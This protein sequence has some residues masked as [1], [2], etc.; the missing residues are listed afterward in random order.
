[1][2]TGSDTPSPSVPD[3]RMFSVEEVAKVLNVSRPYVTALADSGALGVVGRT[4][5]G[6]RR[7]PATAVDAYCVQQRSMSRSA[8]AEIAAISQQAGLYNSDTR[9]G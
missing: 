2:P 6:K 5:S 7:I 9:G 3:D 1:M 4:E 8:L